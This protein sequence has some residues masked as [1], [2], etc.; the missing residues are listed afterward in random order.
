MSLHILLYQKKKGVIDN[1]PPDWA[2]KPSFPFCKDT[3]KKKG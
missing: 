3:L 2:F 1:G